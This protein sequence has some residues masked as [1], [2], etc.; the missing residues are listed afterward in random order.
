MY[1]LVGFVF[2][3]QK[4]QTQWPICDPRKLIRHTVKLIISTTQTI[5]LLLLL[6]LLLLII[7]TAN[8]I[9]RKDVSNRWTGVKTELSNCMESQVATL[10]L[11]DTS[12]KQWY[13]LIVYLTVLLSTNWLH[14]PLSLF[15]MSY[16]YT[17][18]AKLAL[19]SNDTF[20]VFI[21]F[22]YA[23]CSMC[24]IKHLVSRLKPF[25]KTCFHFIFF[26]V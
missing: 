24:L 11:S 18:F 22:S 23:Y 16:M 20:A 1:S 19:I 15:I 25:N 9:S 26:V 17:E 10:Y 2:K 3:V 21:S 7:I 5:P 6:L 14:S 4:K 13:R 8:D 12:T